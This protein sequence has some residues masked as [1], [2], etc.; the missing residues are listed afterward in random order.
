MAGKFLDPVDALNRDLSIGRQRD[1]LRK[2]DIPALAKAAC[3]EPDINDPVPHYRSVETCE[4]LLLAVLP[5]PAAR[6]ESR[7][8]P[9][10]GLRRSD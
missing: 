9:V 5:K 10:A 4:A 7:L 2:V 8:I 6:K 3:R 1:A